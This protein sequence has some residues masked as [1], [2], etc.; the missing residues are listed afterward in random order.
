MKDNSTYIQCFG[1]LGI[2][3]TA[4]DLQNYVEFHKTYVNNYFRLTTHEVLALIEDESA[5]LTEADL[6]LHIPDPELN[7]LTDEDSYESNVKKLGNIND[8]LG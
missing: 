7:G 4:G 3:S 1:L 6:V 5:K 8:N 2:I